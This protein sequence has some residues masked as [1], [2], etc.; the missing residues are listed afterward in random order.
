MQN[1]A[2]ALRL[3]LL[4]SFLFF[5]HIALVL[6]ISSAVLTKLV[7]STTATVLYTAGAMGSV[8]LLFAIPRIVQ[9][10]GLVKTTLAIFILLALSLFTMG[11]TKN[12]HAF[13]VIFVVYSALTST[14]WYCNDM[15]VSHYAYE[16]TMGRI[17]GTYLTIINTAIALMPFLAG[18]LIVKEG[19]SSTFIGAGYLLLIAI[20]VIAVSQR[21][22]VDRVY[23]EPNIRT[24]WQSMKI[25]PALRRVTAL[26]FLLQFFYAVMTIYSPLYLLHVMHFGW[27]TI[28]VIFSLMLTAF[29]IL[30]YPIGKWSDGIGEKKLLITGIAIAGISTIV[31]GTLGG[32]TYSVLIVIVI[33][34]CTRIGA[35]MLEVMTESYFFKQVTDKDEGVISIYRMMYPVA[36]II[37]PL[38]GWLIVRQTSYMTLFI[39]LGIILLM[40]AL[41]SFRLVDIRK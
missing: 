31:F 26:S 19:F 18:I 37:A 22:F 17:R 4:S 38:F 13:V 7:G 41:Y 34:F 12:P 28:G 30:Q 29:I 25:S 9:Q 40:G 23:K 21:H 5:A 14:V 20:G 10:Y 2:K 35:S 6:Y 39:V 24:A 36:Y 32:H 15:F 27:N 11:T 1:S 33:L 16:K 8:I 3:I